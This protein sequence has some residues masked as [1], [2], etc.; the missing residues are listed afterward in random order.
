M[1][2]CD[3]LGSDKIFVDGSA[4]L[5]RSKADALRMLAEML[6]GPLKAEPPVLE[7]LLLEREQLQ[8]TGI[9]D[10][11]AIP[12]ASMETAP[13]RAAALLITPHGVPYDSIDGADATI[14]FGVIGP[15]EATGDHLRVLARISRLLRDASTRQQLTQARSAEEVY[16]LVMA[17]DRGMG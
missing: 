5:I 1:Q 2:I 12:H 14:I 16:A 11:V 6:S 13:G 3:I 15:R 8:S 4:D 7:R 17:R 9:G 10:G